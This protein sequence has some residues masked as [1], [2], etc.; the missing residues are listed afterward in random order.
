MKPPRTTNGW[1]TKI[2]PYIVFT[3]SLTFFAFIAF[4]GGYNFDYRD[5]SVGALTA[6]AIITSLWLVSISPK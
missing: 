1:L 3:I 4:M 5:L 2:K 6:A